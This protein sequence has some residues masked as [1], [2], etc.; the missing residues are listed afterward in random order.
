[1]NKLS[2]NALTIGF[3]VRRLA[4]EIT[5]ALEF[6]RCVALLGPNGSGKT[7]LMRT[8]A[9]TITPLAGEVLL[10]GMPI[11]ARSAR[12][13][14]QRVAYV[15]Q[16]RST[17]LNFRAI[18]IIEMARA[19][20]LAWH[21]R[22]SAGDRA[23]ARHALD[24]IGIAALASRVFNELSGGEQQ[25]VLIAR[26]LAS[27]ARLLLLDEPTASLDFGNQLHVLEV[28]TK[29]KIDG[30]GIAFT[31]HDPH[32]AFD[33]ADTTLTLSRDGAVHY[34]ATRDV[35]TP[36]HLASLYRVSES[37]FLHMPTGDPR[38]TPNS[39]IGGQFGASLE[40]NL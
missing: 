28:I 17:L 15:A 5:F 2:A 24:E 1:M 20:H 3:N 23:I 39:P 11:K 18:E 27:G 35:L 25:L 16:G 38:P 6:G 12:D 37:H 32:H 22:P 4:S 21:A 31:T 8:L 29:L 26:T 10:D 30:Y 14:A 34:G 40:A 33:V 19:P 7:T 36:A 9:G 13:V